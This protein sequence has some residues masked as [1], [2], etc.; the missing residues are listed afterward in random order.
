VSLADPVDRGWG[1]RQARDSKKVPRRFRGLAANPPDLRNTFV[2][3]AIDT[4]WLLLLVGAPALGTAVSALKRHISVAMVAGLFTATMFV[5]WLSLVSGTASQTRAVTHLVAWVVFFS[6]WAPVVGSLRIARPG[7]WWWR[8]RYSYQ[9]QIEAVASYR[10]KH[11][12]G[13]DPEK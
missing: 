12:S 10:P 1:I 11:P 13:S 8:N 5:L 7:S 9:E 6:G 3:L 4:G 2:E